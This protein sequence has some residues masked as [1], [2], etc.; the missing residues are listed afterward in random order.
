MVDYHG[1]YYHVDGDDDGY[2]DNEDNHWDS[3]SEHQQWS[4]TTSA[5]STYL[6][7]VFKTFIASI[8]PATGSS[9][10]T[11]S[12]E[13]PAIMATWSALHSNIDWQQSIVHNQSINRP[14]VMEGWGW[15]QTARRREHDRTVPEAS[16]SVLPLPMLPPPLWV[17]E[18]TL[19][20]PITSTGAA[21]M[22]GA[23]NT[24]SVAAVGVDELMLMLLVLLLLLS[25]SWL[26]ES[27]SMALRWGAMALAPSLC[28]SLSI[29][30][31]CL[32]YST[33][34]FVLYFFS[35]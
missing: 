34:A 11:L 33:A 35:D 26:R 6:A 15:Q 10:L 2:G 5:L 19:S 8:D 27:F 16:L 18:L 3:G 4:A 22:V 21:A 28:S 9:L 24:V 29:C 14:W 23:K 13:S 12:I 25:L 31:M 1:D 20:V 30:A 17:T 7:A 32:L